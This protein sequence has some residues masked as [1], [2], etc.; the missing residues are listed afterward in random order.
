MEIHKAE[1]VSS[2]TAEN[3]C[4]KTGRPEF[5]F[6]GRS[7]VGKSSLINML[8]GRKGLAKVSATPGKTQLINFFN[9]N[10]RWYLV[11]LPGYGYAKVSKSQQ[12]SLANMIE[13]YLAKRQQLV[14]AFVLIDAN[15]PPT[16]VDLDFI[17]SL[18]ELQ[19]PFAIVFTKTDRHKKGVNQTD[20]ISAFLQALSQTWEP[21]PP[22]FLSSSV[23]GAGRTEILD[24]I[25]QVLR[26][27][28]T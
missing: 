14:L 12:R 26:S 11:D 6:I 3:Q 19:V 23:T 13:G 5:A 8:T 2:F 1:F 17:N 4:P 28:S 7:N 15:V 22:H 21:L 24:Y 9:I 25:A 27:L 18:G 10:D 16:R 20:N